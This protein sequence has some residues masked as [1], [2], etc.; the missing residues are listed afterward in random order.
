MTKSGSA[1]GRGRRLVWVGVPLAALVL[2][3]VIWRWDWVIPLVQ[4]RI[5]AALGRPVAI[6]HLHVRIGR[7]VRVTVDD[8]AVGNP[9]GWPTDDPPLA[10]IAH[11]TIDADIWGYFAGRGLVLPLVALD[12]PHIY[13]VQRADGADNFTP[14]T[15]GG[16]GHAPP[17]IGDLRVA[18][19]EAHVVLP[20]LKADF[21]AGIGTEGEGAAAKLLVDARGTYAGQPITARVVGGAL[22]SLRSASTPWP[23][24]LA[25]ANGPTRLSVRGTVQDPVALK[26][27]SLAVQ[28]SGPSLGLLEPLTGLPIPP[29]PAYRVS[30]KVDFA[31]VDKIRFDD[32]RATLGNSDIDGSIVEAP[33]AATG[34]NGQAKPVVTL[35]LHSQRVDLA[36]FNGVFGG[37]PGRAT[38]V[39]ATPEERQRAAEARASPTLLPNKPISIPR[40]R[41]A[42]IH[43]RYHGDHIEGRDIPLDNLDVVM[44]DVNGQITVNPVSFGVGK[45][46]LLSH[47][48]LVPVSDKA[49]R[50]KADVRLDKLDVARL[51]AATHAFGGAG[52]IS[53]VGAID[54]TGDSVASLMAHGNGGLKMAMAGGDL[55]ALLLDLSGLEFGNALLSALGMPKKTAVQCF[56]T[57]LDLHQ[58]IVKV[59]AMVLQTAE[60][61]MSVSGNI[62]LRSE[63]IDLA[64]KTDARHFSVGSLPTRID[65]GGTFRHP[66]IRPGAALAARAGAMAGL[67]VLFAPLAILPTIQFGTSAEQDARCGDLLRQ[68][69]DSA[70]GKTLPAPQH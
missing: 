4:P 21:R 67:G 34:L 66:A 59:A 23:V 41:W 51:M 18:N 31:G 36:D 50:V 25:L 22:L 43:L 39:E 70:G 19:G 3:A 52:S 11:L 20:K 2:L 10:T 56:V 63:R 44:D 8:L 14:S 6:G 49:V 17:A 42:N 33:A 69:R 64:L 54:A 27:G 5:A 45:G 30:G 46:R 38:T 55:S 29:T 1:S 35:D 12:S 58:G 65:I 47:I 26:G 37:V 57:D 62:D 68:A 15:G 13:A 16:A 7:L 40:L 32:L 53:G 9:P 48:D 24:E 60:A 28:A 61:I